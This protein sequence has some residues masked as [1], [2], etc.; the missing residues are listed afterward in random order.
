MCLKESRL[1]AE[2]GRE[3]MEWM[4]V[5]ELH[6]TL[7]YY[8]FYFYYFIILAFLAS[9]SEILN[10][11]NVEWKKRT[12]KLSEDIRFF[13][14]LPTTTTTFSFPFSLPFLLAL[15][16]CLYGKDIF[17][18]YLIS[19]IKRAYTDKQ[20]DFSSRFLVSYSPFPLLLPPSS[21]FL[22]LLVVILHRTI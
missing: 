18:V 16:L 19:S 5:C 3:S 12:R 6:T 21:F 2:V 14:A 7:F 17:N 20:T 4:D 9:L 15:P 1:Q 22:L 11:R 10:E 13:F 8:H